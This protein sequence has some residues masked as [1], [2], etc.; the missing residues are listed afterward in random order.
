MADYETTSFAPSDAVEGGLPIDGATVEWTKCAIEIFDYK[1]KSEY[2]SCALGIDFVDAVS[3]N[4]FERQYISIGSPDDWQP[5]PDGKSM[6]Y[7][8]GGKAGVKTNSNFMQLMAS[9]VNA[10]FPE[11]T[12]KKGDITLLDGLVTRVI[13]VNAP[14]RDGMVQVRK[15]KKTGKEYPVQ[16]LVVDGIDRMPGE[17]KARGKAKGK[18][19]AAKKESAKTEATESEATEVEDSEIRDRAIE[20]VTSILADADGNTISKQQLPTAIIKA[21]QKD[22]DRNAVLKMVNPPEF[23][24]SDDLPW[25]YDADEKTL[26]LS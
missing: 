7:V 6:T 3:E 15:D 10:G 14:K 1:G 5:T 18:G 13:M 22:K 23:H 21:M 26:S 8:G 17:K 16:V 24:E 4:A 11:D 2:P 19:K 20:I 12:L 9:L 25:T